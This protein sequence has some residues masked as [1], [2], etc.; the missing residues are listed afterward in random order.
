MHPRLTELLDY[1]DAQRSALLS[2]V[3]A[4]PSERWVERPDPT[5][6]SVVDLLEHLYRVEHSCAHVIARGV[7][8]ARASGH[9]EETESHSVLAALDAFAIPDRSQRRE[10][11]ERVAPTGGWSPG[12]AREKLNT[13]RAELHAAMRAGD[14]LKLGSIR[15]THA[16]LGELDLYGWILFIGKHEARHVQQAR[17]IVEQVGALPRPVATLS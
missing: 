15:Q 8:A 1:V 6:W 10:A 16:R 2:A 3:S 5:R 9:P 11:P 13:S 7:E 14:G 12:E 4:L 17:E